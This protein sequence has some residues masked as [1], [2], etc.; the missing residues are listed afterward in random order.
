LRNGMPHAH[1]ERSSPME[2]ADKLFVALGAEADITIGSR[3]L[4]SGLQT[5]RQPLYRQLLG[6]TFNLMLRITLGLNFKDTLCGF[7]VFTR[8]LC[9]K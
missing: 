7:K 8:W 5:Q 9:E 2:E 6:R 3:W 1:G 4:G